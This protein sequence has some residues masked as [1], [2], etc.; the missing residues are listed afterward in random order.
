MSELLPDH[1]RVLRDYYMASSVEEA[2]AYL[3][4]H[5]GDAQII[6]GGTKLMPLLQRGQ[7]VATRLVDVSRITSMKR[8][9]IEGEFLV[10]GGAV[11]YAQLLI[12]ELVAGHMPI[13]AEVAQMVGTTQLRQQASLAGSIVHARGNSEGAIT[14][15]A[16]GAEAEIANLTGAQWMP[17]R[18]LFVRPG[19]SRVNSTAEIVTAV[20]IPLLGVGQGAAVARVEPGPG[21]GYSPLIA[22]V[23]LGLGPDDDALDWFTLSVGTPSSVPRQWQLS[24]LANGRPAAPPDLRQAALAAALPARAASPE[25]GAPDP[26]QAS[27]AIL[28]AYDQ[29]LARARASRAA[30]PATAP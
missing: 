27:A 24:E 18:A 26:Q 3:A 5:P 4:A 16:L 9:R 8:V 19:V 12:K 1:R 7:A 30:P 6:G 28:A 17:V 29:A 23:A 22:A 25:E 10:I 15:I 21:E 13:L 11:T 2:I 20:R 14:L